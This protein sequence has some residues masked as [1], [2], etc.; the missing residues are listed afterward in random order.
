LEALQSGEQSVLTNE[1]VALSKEV[2]TLTKPSRFGKTDMNR[3][4][5]LFA[6]Y[7]E[8]NIFFSTHELDHGRRDSVTA[9]KQVCV[10]TNASRFWRQ[11]LTTGYISD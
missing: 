5:E 7:L 6:I 8:A 11:S 10:S 4:R 9:T 1:I 3:W 2:A